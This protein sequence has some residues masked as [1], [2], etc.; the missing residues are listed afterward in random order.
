MVLPAQFQLGVELTNIVN[1]ISQAVSALGSLALVD[2]I[3]KSGSDAITETKFAS[4]IG[5]HRIDPI[6]KTYFREAVSTADQS[7]ISRYFDI[8]LESG[9]GPTVRE[10]LKKPALFSMVI[11]LSAL[12][13]SHED[14]PLSNAIVEAIERIVRESGKDFDLVP[15][16]VSLLGTI[17][18]CQQQIVAFRWSCLYEAVEY[19]IQDALRVA[20][21]THPRG[22]S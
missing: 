10:S 4:L 19:R 14:E 7:V 8:I 17:R 5:K 20:G 21:E 3:R 2:A 12:A 18:A 11:Q 15:D 16:Y 22:G 13:F 1:P 9:S 6:I